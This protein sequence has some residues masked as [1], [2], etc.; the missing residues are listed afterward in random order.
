MD[1]DKNTLLHQA[2]I[3]NDLEQVKEILK[4]FKGISDLCKTNVLDETPL[5]IA[6]KKEYED[7][8]DAIV[9]VHKC[10]D[11]QDE[12]GYTALMIA[13]MRRNER[14]IESLLSNGANPS[15]I[16]SSGQTA[17]SILKDLGEHG[18]ASKIKSME[19]ELSPPEPLTR[20]ITTSH[21][22][23]GREDTCLYH[24]LAKLYGQNIFKIHTTTWD[25]VIC[26]K[27][28]NTENPHNFNIEPPCDKNKIMMFYYIYLLLKK[29]Y[30]SNGFP[31]EDIPDLIGRVQQKEIPDELIDY[32]SWIDPFLKD[33]NM[34]YL[35]ILFNKHGNN[36]PLYRYLYY[37]LK[38][39][40]CYVGMCIKAQ[41][42]FSRYGH[43]LLVVG[44]DKDE[45][46]IK[47][48]WKNTFFH[49]KISNLHKTNLWIESILFIQCDVTFYFLIDLMSVNG[50]PTTQ[51]EFERLFIHRNTEINFEG[52]TKRKNKKKRKSKRMRS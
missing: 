41:G 32:T 34:L 16:T 50:N 35:P 44:F 3:E 38:N 21:S 42:I 48:S 9:N 26:D 15:I 5:H 45:L 33:T 20:A 43:S 51:T 40:N 7:I 36:T 31:I 27:Y 23:Q 49:L 13:C 25:P 4:T 11:I 46:I 24:T 8:V 1:K 10:I 28:L 29:K 18:L 39:L 2:C 17:I 30:K 47:N 52:G 22:Y 37:V 6:C 14:I 19:S 12:N